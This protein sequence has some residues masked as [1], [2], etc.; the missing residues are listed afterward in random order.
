MIQEVTVFSPGDSR[1]LTCWS[2]VPYLFTQALEKKGIKVNRV[3]IYSNKYIRKIIWNILVA[4]ILNRLY[5]KHAYTYERTALNRF[6]INRKIRRAQ[7]RYKGSDLNILIGYDYLPRPSSKKSLLL[8]DWT[9]EYLY[10]QRYHKSP[11]PWVEREMARQKAVIEKAD[12]VIS[13]FPD[14]AEYMRT[15]YKNPNIFYLGQNVIN[16]AYDGEIDKNSLILSKYDSP[17]LLFI[18]GI[19]YLEGAKLLLQSFSALK[20]SYPQLELH[21]IGLSKSQLPPLSEGVYCYG[22][23]DK[24]KE[25]E[26]RCYYDL[27]LRAKLLIN[28]TP[29][30]SGYSSSIEALYFYTPVIVSKYQSFVDTFGER[31]AFGAYIEE[32]R[33]PV[34][35]GLIRSVLDQDE[36][37]YRELCNAAHEAVKHFTWDAY[38]EKLISLVDR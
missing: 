14:I 11:T 26:R 6:L 28:P 22:Y 37:G 33:A 19:G 15:K 9:V 18:G 16:N 32:H 5:G 2:N 10:T 24:S 7:K 36:A 30:W 13:L 1:S 35:S 27:L 21:I 3:N 25:E 23:L 29:E 20:Q 31:P 12:Y 17:I 34:L 4:P 38:V 8:S